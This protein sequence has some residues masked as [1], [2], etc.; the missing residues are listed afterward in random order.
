MPTLKT[1]KTIKNKR[2]LLDWIEAK[3]DAVPEFADAGNQVNEKEIVFHV[4]CEFTDKKGVKR[5]GLAV[6]AGDKNT[7]KRM[8]QVENC[9]T[10]MANNFGEMKEYIECMPELIR[11]IKIQQ[12]EFMRCFQRD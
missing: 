9:V 10:V 5:N 11:D 2:A 8:R 4:P 1:S 3:I 6:C 7:V 12:V